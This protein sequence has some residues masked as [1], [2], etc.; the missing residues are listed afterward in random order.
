MIAVG[1]RRQLVENLTRLQ[2]GLAAQRLREEQ[3]AHRPVHRCERLAELFLIRRRNQTHVSKRE[4]E[5]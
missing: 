2:A 5:L 1:Q 3:Q 4:L